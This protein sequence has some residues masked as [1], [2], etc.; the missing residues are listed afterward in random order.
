MRHGTTYYELALPAPTAQRNS[1][2]VRRCEGRVERDVFQLVDIEIGA[3]QI[4]PARARLRFR[5]LLPRHIVPLTLRL[6]Q[7]KPVL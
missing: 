7:S 6:N 5:R 2:G 1:V 3:A 4:V